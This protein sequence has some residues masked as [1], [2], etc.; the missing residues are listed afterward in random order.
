MDSVLIHDMKNVGFRLRLLLGNLEEHYG[1]PEFRRSAVELL[2]CTLEKL[3][4]IIGRRAANEEAVLIKVSLDL[5]DLLRQVIRT[6]RVRDESGGRPGPPRVE[7]QFG[8]LV[9]VWGD[10][11]Y[12]GDAFSSIVQ[13]ALEAAAD[14]TPVSIRTSLL[15]RGRSRV[16]VEIEDHGPGMTEEFV[17][18]HLFRPFQTT[19]PEGVG[20]G[21][22]TARQIVR[23]HH[24]EVRVRSRPG[25]GTR[26]R[27]TLP[28]DE[29]PVP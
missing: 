25:K 4:A 12:L 10:P 20:L 13:N 26:V 19:K 23:F 6:V 9:P 14:G 15:R 22:Y 28:A 1:N 21:L 16:V 24:G 29:V 27:V 8:L 18:E 7:T 17:R 2:H 11:Y 5:N 3:D